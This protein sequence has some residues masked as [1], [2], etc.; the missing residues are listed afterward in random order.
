MN[1]IND[2]DNIKNENINL[3]NEIEKLNEH[4][5]ELNQ[6]LDAYEKEAIQSEQEVNILRE[7][8]NNLL[9]IRDQLIKEIETLKNNQNNNA[10]INDEIKINE[11]I[12]ETKSVNNEILFTQKLKKYV[13]KVLFKNK[14]QLYI[15]LLSTQKME[16]LIIEN[17]KLNAERM[18]LN[19]KVEILTELINNPESISKYVDEN[20]NINIQYEAG[21][22]NMLYNNENQI[23]NIE[24]ENGENNISN[25]DN[26]ND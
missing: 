24:E 10:Q 4:I 7:T 25:K 1:E 19:Q 9:L 6:E 14:T 5:K 15:N 22:E 8:N 20:D 18:E 17:T 12:E 11:K 13:D 3:K 21:E 26:K 2:L 16:N 23:E